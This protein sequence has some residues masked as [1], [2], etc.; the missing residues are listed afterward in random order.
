LIDGRGGVAH[1]VVVTVQGGR[2]AR[3]DAGAPPGARVTYDLGP[4]TLLPGLVDA[5]V[6]LGWYFNRRGV[7]HRPGDGDTPEDS[8]RAIAANAKAMLDAGVTTVQSVG[9]PEDGPVRDSIAAGRIPGPRVLTS[10]QPIIDPRP[11]PDQMRMI[12]RARVAQGADLVKL[13]ASEG[14]G[15]GGG[16]TLTD[17]QLDAICGE[18]RALGRRTVVHAMTAESVRAATRAG[19]TEIEHGLFATDDDLRAMAERGTFFGPQ[20]CLVFRNY[21]DFRATY[22]RSG[23]SPDAFDVLAH[24]LPTARATFQRALRTPGLQVIFSTDAVAGAHG[25]NAEELVCRV[26]EGGQD[27]MAALVS[28]TSLAAHALGLA[29]RVGAVAAGLDADL[30]AVDGD[31]LRDI[32]AMRRVAFVMRGGSVYRAP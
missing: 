25:R 4:R 17:E 29:D 20:V 1:D 18:A 2:V 27:P 5:H 14:L 9:G 26:R 7:L 28:A 21:L 24:A 3:V 6:H 8:Y 16:Q 32:T 11:T 12:V 31:P 23:F 22:A 13:F 10:L 30:V 19:C 15:G